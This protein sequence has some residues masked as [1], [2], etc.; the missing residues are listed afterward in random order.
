MGHSSSK[1]DQVS[2]YT[3]AVRLRTVRLILRGRLGKGA[4][5][6]PPGR[7]TSPDARIGQG[8]LAR[9]LHTSVARVQLGWAGFDR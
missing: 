4:L 6:R 5:I 7:A 8:F 3:Q 9:V 2:D 1:D